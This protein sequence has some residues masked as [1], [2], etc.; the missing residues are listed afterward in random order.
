MTMVTRK[1]AAKLKESLVVAAELA[2][3][4]LD[5]P[6]RPRTDLPEL[7][8]D[9]TDLE[10]GSLMDLLVLL[11]RWADYSGG[12]LAVADVD[13]QYAIAFVDQLKARGLVETYDAGDEQDTPKGKRAGITVQRASKAL[14]PI[15]QG[16]VQTKLNAY[17]RRKLISARHAAFERD[18]AVVSRELSRR[19]ERDPSARRTARLGGA[20]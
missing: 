15:Y 9:L 4:S 13:E 19:I 20:R 7:H 17:A 8:G 12:Q 2:K 10:D 18:A 3:Q 11:T 1:R 6:S 5:L 16:A 14:D